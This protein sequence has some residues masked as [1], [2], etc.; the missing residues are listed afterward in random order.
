MLFSAL[1]AD[2]HAIVRRGTRDVLENLGGGVAAETGS[3]EEALRLLE[4]RTPD[5]LVT[6]LSLSSG[7]GLEL[8][9]HVQEQ[10]LPT[11]PLVLTDEDEAP[12][13]SAAFQ[14]G[15]RGYSLKSVPPGAVE[16][17]IRTVL[18]G[19]TYLTDRLPRTL[20]EQPPGDAV[21]ALIEECRSGAPLEET[22]PPTEPFDP[23]EALTRRES[24]VL[25]LTAGGLTAP[26]IGDLL[27]ISYRTVEKHQEHIR[28]KLGLDNKIEM[29]GYAI[30]RGLL[31]GATDDEERTRLEHAAGPAPPSGLE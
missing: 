21:E 26:E 22:G 15:A 5:L 24:Q 6:E 23:L 4:D 14:L 20:I 16:A 31:G 28:E 2:P 27:S 30:R 7:N 19:E 8:L 25:R 29:T 10:S 1:I 17:A 13:V 11:R 9:A 12:Y 18:S 3:G